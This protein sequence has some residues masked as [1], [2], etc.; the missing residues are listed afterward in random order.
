[1][2]CAHL[3]PVGRLCG[4]KLTKR[5]TS[6]TGPGATVDSFQSERESLSSRPLGREKYGWRIPPSSPEPGKA[7]AASSRIGT[8]DSVRTNDAALGAA[9]SAYIQPTCE[10]RPEAAAL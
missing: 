2:L 8:P 5:S 9:K 7:D 10:G 3:P 1:M 4:A 6:H